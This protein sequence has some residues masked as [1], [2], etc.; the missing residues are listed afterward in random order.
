MREREA[1]ALLLAFFH[2]RDAICQW[3]WNLTRTHHSFQLRIEDT[4]LRRLFGKKSSWEPAGREVA[5]QEMLA[6]ARRRERRPARSSRSLV[7]DRVRKSW[8]PL[9]DPRALMASSS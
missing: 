5:A 4:L 8:P 3:T 7:K 6:A 9:L 2:P 1:T